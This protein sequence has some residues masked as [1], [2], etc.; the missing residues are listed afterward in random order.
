MNRNDYRRAFI[1]LRPAQPGW[2][3]HVRLER[4]TM[5]GSMYFIITP[6]ARD[7]PARAA[8]AGRRGNEYY[9]ASLGALRPD[10]RG[11]LTLASAFDPRNID[12]R[13]LEA[14]QLIVIASGGRDCAVALTG[15]VDGAYPMDDARVQEAV[16]A[17]YASDP[18]AADLPA[19]GEAL[20]GDDV[21]AGGAGTAPAP[22][23]PGD[24]LP[25]GESDDAV[26]VPEPPAA[27]PDA[28]GATST[29]DS[30][31]LGFIVA[32]PAPVDTAPDPVM[33]APAPDVPSP[34]PVIT[35]PETV[36]TSPDPVASMPEGVAS[37]LE[38]VDKTPPDAIPA[39]E[40]IVREA[41]EGPSQA[42]TIP[43]GG[44]TRIYTRMRAVQ[45]QASASAKDT[46]AKNSAVQSPETEAP[47]V[48]DTPAESPEPQS[49][50]PPL[51]W[52]V[53]DSRTLP[54]PCTM[55]LED[56][57]AYVRAPLPKACGGWCLV[58]VRL[59]G[60]D[61]AAVRLAIPG[62]YAA[63]PPEGIEDAVWVGAGSRGY[64]VVTARCGQGDA[65]TRES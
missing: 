42:Q 11:Q 33:A 49:A 59:S 53:R 29:S 56:G 16:C 15:N 27:P 2:A 34:D 19:P 13:P 5:T 26:G 31:V 4:R 12:G 30:P 55:P 47:H 21:D 57:Y 43:E 25:G 6:G 8:L 28:S 58:G 64:W 62:D 41:E 40:T 35:A 14:Y 24:A 32:A 38:S 50:Q 60:E 7:V 1:M 54:A 45:P 18:P 37:A 61:V 23:D 22:S 46:T 51:L 9:A 52:R 10:S 17:L 44:P 20:P 36:V 48:P 63:T 3:G 65:K 39:P